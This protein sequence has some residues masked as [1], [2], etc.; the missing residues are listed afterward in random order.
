MIRSVP[1]V[2]LPS[3]E[4]IPKLGQGTW[5]MGERQNARKSEIAA[6]R[7][8]VELSMTLI[9]TAEM[10]GDGESEKLIAEALGDRRDELFIVSKVYPAQRQRARGAGRVRAQP[11]AS[12]DR[13][14]RSLSAAL[15]RRRGSR[16]R[17]RR[18]REIEARRH[19]ARRQDPSL[20]REQLRHRRH[21]RALFARRRRRL[22]HRSDS[23]QRRASRAR[24]RSFAVAARAPHARDG[25]QPRRSRAP[26]ARRRAGEDRGGARRVGVSGGACVGA[27]AARSVRDT[28]GCRCRARSGESRGARAR[29]PPTN[30]RTSIS[31]SGRRSRSARSKCFDRRG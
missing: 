1:T 21:G 23:V 31:S 27:A 9:D 19:E 11:E 22:R 3:G 13:S 8:G 16:R 6:L 2:T 5:E 10:Y 20:G 15:A 14:H 28:K 4:A 12:E 30:W 29:L 17:G 26:A 18:L 24:V 25:V 7:E